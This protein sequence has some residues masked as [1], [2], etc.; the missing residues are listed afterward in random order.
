M[1]PYGSAVLG[2]IDSPPTSGN[3]STSGRADSVAAV[4]EGWL[5]VPTT[6]VWTLSTRSN[7]GSRLLIGN[8]VV[9]LNPYQWV[10]RFGEVVL[11]AG[12]HPFRVEFFE[13][14]GTAGLRVRW[15]GP[16]TTRATIPA[17]AYLHGGTPMAID[18]DG[19]GTVG[20]GDLAVLLSAWGPAASG[21]PADFNRDGSVDA[22]DLS[23]VLANWG[24]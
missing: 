19:D 18:L 11:E 14:F 21:T 6:G 22:A 15:Q 13:N 1:T 4:F 12:L 5:L 24:L 20:A 17:S 16:G 23:R 2:A 9:V 10:E 7:E 8:Q 3:F